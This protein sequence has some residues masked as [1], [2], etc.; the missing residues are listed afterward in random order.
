MN[1]ENITPNLIEI[2][3]F[4]AQQKNGYLLDVN[5]NKCLRR[6]IGLVLLGIGI[7]F[8]VVLF[9][10]GLL[11]GNQNFDSSYAVMELFMISGAGLLGI[12]IFESL[13]IFNKK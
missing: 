5:G 10:Y 7:M 13:N 6:T 9:W 4:N 11:H 2:N 12:N 3:D 8:G 1:N